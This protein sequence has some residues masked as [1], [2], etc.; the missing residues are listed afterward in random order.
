MRSCAVASELHA[1]AFFAHI[2][3][4][5]EKMGDS[6]EVPDLLAEIDE[7]DAGASRFGRDLEAYQ[8]AESHAVDEGQIGEVENDTLVVGNEGVNLVVELA[9]E[10][11]DKTAATVDERHVVFAL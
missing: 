9:A 5:R 3:E 6:Q 11:G 8:G 2:A 10:P 4:E 7:L 1:H